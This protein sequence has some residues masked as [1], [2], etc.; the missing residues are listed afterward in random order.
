MGQAAL[1]DSQLKD[2]A[3]ILDALRAAQFDVTAAAWI[4]TRD[5]GQWYLYIA[6]QEV[7]RHGLTGAYRAMLPIVDQIQSTWFDQFDIKLIEADSP[8]SKAVLEAVERY[9]ARIPK[10]FGAPYLGS[11]SIDDAVLY[12]S[13]LAVP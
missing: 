9:A 8:L 10:R 7:N 1:V 6:S 5:E 2:G 12:P 3:R 13:D 11:L 4:K